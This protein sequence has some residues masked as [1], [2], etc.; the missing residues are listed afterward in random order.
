[1][2]DRCK[3]CRGEAQQEPER[4]NESD[5]TLGPD[6]H[7]FLQDVSSIKRREQLHRSSR[8]SQEW[9]LVRDTG[10][11]GPHSHDDT[12]AAATRAASSLGGIGLAAKRSWRALVPVSGRADPRCCRLPRVLTGRPPLRL[13]NGRAMRVSAAA[14]LDLRR[15]QWKTLC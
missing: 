2:R 11:A 7:K 10:I 6:V 5:R 13:P 8:A 14:A 4:S 3:N 1:M 12:Q 9:M 15:G